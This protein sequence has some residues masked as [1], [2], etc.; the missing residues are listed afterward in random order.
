MSVIPVYAASPLNR[1]RK[2]P[3]RRA[4]QDEMQQRAEFLLEYAEEQQPVTIRQ[5]YYRASATHLAGIGKDEN[6]YGKIQRQVLKLRRAG[7]MP[8]EWIADA[9]RWMRKPRSFDDVD[10]ALRTT[11]A[12]Y[13]KNLWADADSYVEIWLEKDA[14]AGVISPITYLYDVPLMV[15]RGY[16]SET[17]AFESI[18]QR[19]G[20]QTPY[21][22][23]ALYDFDRS[24]RDAANSLKEK[25][26]R[27]AAEA[28]IEVHFILLGI[29]ERQATS[30]ADLIA[31]QRPHKRNTAA[32]Q[33]WPHDYGVE[34]DAYRPTYLRTLVETA[35]NQHLPQAQLHVLKEAE[36]SERT[37]LKNLIAGRRRRR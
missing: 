36:E 20:D 23:Y 37:I 6:S 2:K 4:T 31:G 24:G 29:T 7:E 16:T 25:L 17:F 1:R 27:F 9:T 14:L 12:L 26:E 15:T 10:E 22:V 11:A 5:L 34:L 19:G 35:I 30:N 33:K 21:Y 18:A 13:R 8:Y 28:G 32:D 3:R